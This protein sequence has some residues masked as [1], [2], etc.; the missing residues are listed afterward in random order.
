MKQSHISSNSYDETNINQQ[1]GNYP[2]TCDITDYH[3]SYALDNW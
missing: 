1:N 3:F 2:D